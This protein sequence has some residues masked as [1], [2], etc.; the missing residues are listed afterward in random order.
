MALTDDIR[1]CVFF[2]GHG[3]DEHFKSCGTAF[4][5]EYD[6]AKYI[7]TAG[8]V[9]RGLGDDPFA[10]R[11]NKVD[12]T[13]ETFTH[14]PHDEGAAWFRWYFSDDPNVD[15]AIIPFNFVLSK[16]GLELKALRG[17]EWI[18]DEVKYREER[19]GLGDTCY[20]V[21]LFRVLQGAR[22]NVPILHTGNLA[23]VAGEERVPV[24]DRSR[25]G[26]TMLINAHLVELANLEGLSGA[27]VFI[28][29]ELEL[30][31]LTFG[32]HGQRNMV[33]KDSRLHL[34]GVWQGSWDQEAPAAR[35][36]ERVP[37]GVGIVVPASD[38][39]ALL[40][41]KDVVEERN[42]F[43]HAAALAEM[44]VTDAKETSGPAA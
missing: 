12:G 16:M 41:Q 34:L 11:I 30:A 14:D 21:G 26:K 33:A 15:L 18:L 40:N 25:P 28:R 5:I 27:P 35:A 20:A 6:N 38:L 24:R 36:G 23:L 13:S 44:A 1:K 17:G 3:E 9:A 37:V 42:R 39:L 19:V 22:R 7:V 29:G 8:H 10:V 31:G 32:E 4:L 2:I 43:L